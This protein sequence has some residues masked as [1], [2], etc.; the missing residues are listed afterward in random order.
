MAEPHRSQEPLVPDRFDTY[1]QEMDYTTIGMSNQQ[2][3][4]APSV[5]RIHSCDSRPPPR[6]SL[7]ATHPS[8]YK[9]SDKPVSPS[10]PVPIAKRSS[11]SP[12]VAST[13]SGA[14]ANGRPLRNLN[15][16]VPPWQ[17]HADPMYQTHQ[18]DVAVR[19][20]NSLVNFRADTYY[21][22][23]NVISPLRMITLPYGGVVEL[24][25]CYS[26][27][28]QQVFPSGKHCLRQQEET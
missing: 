27:D 20:L 22:I 7:A 19:R 16:P 5:S 26:K 4:K 12:A 17:V 13:P 3:A 25:H 11:Q 24:A 9:A 2:A 15:P 10:S 21:D 18:G 8:L 6:P 28:A 23:G 14:S 1:H